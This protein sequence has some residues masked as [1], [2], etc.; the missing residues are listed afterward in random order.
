MVTRACHAQQCL[1]TKPRVSTLGIYFGTCSTAREV[2]LCFFS[3][4][5]A[6]IFRT[7]GSVSFKHLRAR[8]SIRVRKQNGI[9]DLVASIQ[10]LP[11][12][13]YLCTPKIRQ[14]L[15]QKTPQTLRV[16]AVAPLQ[17]PH[18]VPARAFLYGHV[19]LLEVVLIIIQIIVFVYD[20][21]PGQCLC[22]I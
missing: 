11:P 4:T 12:N 2:L 19:L 7:S 5:C 9:S 14:I 22:K 20:A 13:R 17:R 21:E 15:H 8:A 1:R 16:H 6:A 18:R 10:K 3:L